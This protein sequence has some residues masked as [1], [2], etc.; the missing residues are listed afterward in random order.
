MV[1][2]GVLLEWA[3]ALANVGFVF[4][5]EQLNAADNRAGGGVAKRAERFAADV[6]ADVEQKIE[7]FL[8]A[9]SMFEPVQ[10]FGEPVGSFAT[11]GAFAARFVA[12]EL[13][14]AQHGIND[15]GIFVHDNDSTRAC[16][17]TGGGDGLEIK[18][19]I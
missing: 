1:W 2:F 14:H 7:V 9:V 8:A 10:D 13:A 16:H 19:S 5:A 3:V 6:I 15:A 11:G 4:V 12:V 18:Q 17:R